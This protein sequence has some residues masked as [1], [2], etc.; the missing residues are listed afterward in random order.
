MKGII[1]SSL[2]LVMVASLKTKIMMRMISRMKHGACMTG[3]YWMMNFLPGSAGSKHGVN[4]IVISDSCHSGSITKGVDE[5]VQD[6]RVKRFVPREQLFETFQANRHIYEPFMRMPLVRDDEIAASVLQLGAC[7]DNE[8]AMEDGNNGLFT[9][10]IMKILERNGDIGSY[11]ELLVRSKRA[12]T[13][14]QRPN[15]ICYG[16]NHQQLSKLK[17]FGSSY[18]PGTANRM[19]FINEYRWTYCRGN[20]GS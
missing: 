18:I 20:R 2:I 19:D 9:K 8:Y 10:T 6:T 11:Q 13:G 17:P 5:P 12:L 7:Q 15:L 4:I 16:N 1:L 14:I 3:S